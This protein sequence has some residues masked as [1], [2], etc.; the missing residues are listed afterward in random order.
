[1]RTNL[2]A[3][4]AI[5]AIALLLASSTPA[6]AAPSIERI[7][8]ED[9]FHDTFLSAECG[10]DVT[11]TISGFRIE[12]EFVD[13]AGNLVELAT[14]SI[15]GTSSSEFGSVRIMDVG[16]DQVK[17][18]PDGTVTLTVTGQVPFAFVGALVLDLDTNEVVKEPVLRGDK[19][20]E[21]A[22]RLLADS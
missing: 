14:I 12:R 6:H 1:M 20:L 19:Q 13:G 9:T 22:C 18:A 4:T 2:S 17:V 21:K 11:T 15:R 8:F 16:A 3:A 10:V 7:P 5:S